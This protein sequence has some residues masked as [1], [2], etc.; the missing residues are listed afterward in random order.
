VAK[1]KKDDPL[2]F[3]A[4]LKSAALDQSTREFEQFRCRTAEDAKEDREP[5]ARELQPINFL[6]AI[7]NVRVCPLESIDD[8]EELCA[9]FLGW[10]GSA[11]AEHS[12]FDAVVV[13]AGYDQRDIFLTPLG[14]RSGAALHA[15]I[16]YSI[17]APLSTNRGRAFLWDLAIGMSAAFIL[18]VI[19]H[20]G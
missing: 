2:H 16:G 8:V 10:G 15:Y 7:E 18:V 12:R 17:S 5:D 19:W 20:R 6:G 14:Q 4:Q 11:G 9:R 1:Y 3:A 13:G